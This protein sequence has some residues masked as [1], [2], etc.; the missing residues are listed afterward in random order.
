MSHAKLLV[1]TAKWCAPCQAMK[2]A[3]TWE[4]LAAHFKVPVE[5]MNCDDDATEEKA[6]AAKVQAFPTAQLLDEH[7]KILAEFEG[8]GPLKACI[9]LFTEILEDAEALQPFINKKRGKR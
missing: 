2:K 5:Y 7:G 8:A 1:W 6:T 9:Q 4:K 3:G